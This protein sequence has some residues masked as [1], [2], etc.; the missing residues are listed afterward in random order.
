MVTQ[1]TAHTNTERKPPSAIF[2]TTIRM[3]ILTEMRILL[4]SVCYYGL[5]QRSIKKSKSGLM[6]KQRWHSAFGNND[7]NATNIQKLK[8]KITKFSQKS[9]TSCTFK[10]KTSEAFS[11]RERTRR[12]AK[13]HRCHTEPRAPTTVAEC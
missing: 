12:N 3:C 10:L 4:Y 13:V 11:N 7:K 1:L 2:L 5:L 8:G 6:Q 9:H